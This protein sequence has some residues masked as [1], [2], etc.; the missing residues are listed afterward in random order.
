MVDGVV[1]RVEKERKRREERGS[2]R[3]SVVTVEEEEEGRRGRI[4]FKLAKSQERGPP[5]SYNTQKEKSGKLDRK[6]S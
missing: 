3:A 4:R 6:I 1:I 5:P 2:E